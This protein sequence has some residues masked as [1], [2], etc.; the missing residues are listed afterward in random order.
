MGIGVQEEHCDFA[1]LWLGNTGAQL[2]V[3]PRMLD[4]AVQE[5]D[6]SF[7]LARLAEVAALAEKLVSPLVL[8]IGDSGADCPGL[9][10]SMNIG[11]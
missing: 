6:R 10:K 9:L 7:G 3:L 2:T 1:L 4:I 5:E 8:G 11:A